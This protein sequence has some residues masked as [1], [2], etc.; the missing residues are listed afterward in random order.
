[1]EDRVGVEW[2]IGNFP[3][4]AIDDAFQYVFFKH[5]RSHFSFL[6]CEWVF[7]LSKYAALAVVTTENRFFLL[8]PPLSPVS[9]FHFLL[10]SSSGF[11]WSLSLLRY[12]YEPQQK[13]QLTKVE[14]GWAGQP[15]NGSS[16]S[17]TTGCDTSN[18]S[19]NCFG[20][21]S[22]VSWIWAM[23][24]VWHIYQLLSAQ[25]VTYFK[26]KQYRQ[27]CSVF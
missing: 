9:C 24:L 26:Q 3:P 6:V 20:L 13:N 5:P 8:L 18:T 27:P 10:E 1:M 4:A 7:L 12:P 19:C 23:I 2:I 16:S 15:F 17:S 25:L 11:P 22:L 14:T 21:S